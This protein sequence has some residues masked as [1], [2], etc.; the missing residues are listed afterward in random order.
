V[1]PRQIT[2][3]GTAPRL[4]CIDHVG[5]ADPFGT[6]DEAALF[7]R[8]VLGLRAV[9]LP[10]LG[11]QRTAHRRRWRTVGDRLDRVHDLF[12]ALAGS[13]RRWPAG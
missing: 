11:R 6:F 1:A 5:L 12:P 8:S 3:S 9:E 10:E 2:T 13:T 7:Y 4:C